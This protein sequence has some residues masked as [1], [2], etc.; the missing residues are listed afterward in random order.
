MKNTVHQMLQNVPVINQKINL[1][2]VVAKREK[3]PITFAPH[4]KLYKKNKS[5]NF[6]SQQSIQNSSMQ[7]KIKHNKIYR[8]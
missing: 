7:S 8:M 4:R 3:L 2:V 1:I 5:D 6:L